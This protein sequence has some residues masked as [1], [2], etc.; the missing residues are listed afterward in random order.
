MDIKNIVAYGFIIFILI[1]AIMM[2]YKDTYCSIGNTDYGKGR[3]NAYYRYKPCD[4][5]S[6]CEL[7]AKLI[8]TS[9]YEFNSTSWRLCMI[10]AILASLIGLSI[11]QCD[12]PDIESLAMMIVVI[13]SIG[14]FVHLNYQQSIGIPAT[15]Q[16][17]DIA[18]RL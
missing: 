16:I 11:I 13:F 10:V 14:Y 2:E 15:N 5:N 4:S 6:R 1:Y 17:I 7:K 18:D 8:G 12:L 3:G 9:R